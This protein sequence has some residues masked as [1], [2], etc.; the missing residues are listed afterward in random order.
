MLSNNNFTQ[1]MHSCGPICQSQVNSERRDSQLWQ[2]MG[3]AAASGKF[4]TRDRNA[5]TRVEVTQIQIR[6]Y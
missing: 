4:L 3:V 2:N 6:K 5:W 1:Q